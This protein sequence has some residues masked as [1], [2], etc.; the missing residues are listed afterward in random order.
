MLALLADEH[1]PRQLIR[2]L[3]RKEPELDIV[4][5]QDIGLRSVPDPE[6][7]EWAAQEGRVLI[8]FDVNT[9]L[10]AAYQRIGQGQ[11]MPGVFAITWRTSLGQ[12]IE[13][14]LALAIASLP[15]EWEGQVV[16]LPL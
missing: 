12:N 11:A 2:G 7:L 1:V 13:D 8:T 14:L 4:R 15:N 6:L 10:D 5:A 16:Y 3:L 9:V